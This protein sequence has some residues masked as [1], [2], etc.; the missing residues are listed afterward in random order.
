MSEP[1]PV[2]SGPLA[3]T[4]VVELAGIG[5]G[6]FATML[7]ADLGADVIRVDRIVP[8][9][10]RLEQRYRKDVVN[11][12]KRS[13]AVDLKKPDGRDL[14][15][16]LI[17]R[18]DVLVEGY[19]PGVAERL[20]LGPEDCA[21]RNPRLVYSRMT[22]WGQ[23][24]PL[25][26]VA[27]H[28]IGYL[29]LT[30]ALWGI[31][32]AGEAPVA[33]LNLV[34]DYAGGS[35]FLVM[36]TLAALL[37]ARAGGLG[38]V[39]DAAMVDGVSVLTTMITALSEMGVWD[40]TRRG[41]NAFDSAAPYYDVYECADGKWVAVGPLEQ[42]FFAEMV[43]I[44]GFREG[45][46]NRFVQPSQD[47]WPAHKQEWAALWRTRTRDEW[48]SLLGGTD[49]CVQPVL[50]WQERTRHPHL[51]ARG[52]YVELDG[53]TQPAPAP[54]LSR[55]SL[56]V[57]GPACYPGEHT[58][59]IARALGLTDDRLDALVAAGVVSVG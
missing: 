26:Q 46:D 24:G 19:R 17:E 27:G 5:P 58:R 22:G 28:D 13:I 55:T 35:L 54:R 38:Q 49:A 41:A 3:G 50:D 34:A 51:A 57:S 6:P 37:E 11:R 33:P 30:G 39:V 12:G 16:D 10:P 32:R 18:A 7:L 9:D 25:S 36:G 1:R 23:E 40:P 43:R 29:A 59:E 42:H 14:V 20:G 15:L 52:T 56:S 2:T 8:G 21:A 44:T 48:A 45:D 53:I 31:G 47:E 4:V